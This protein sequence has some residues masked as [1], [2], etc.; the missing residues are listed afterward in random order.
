MF[1]LNSLL[2]KSYSMKQR[3]RPITKPLRPPIFKRRLSI[4]RKLALESLICQTLET[5][6][7]YFL[8]IQTFLIIQWRER[9]KTID[10]CENISREINQSTTVFL[11]LY[12]V[13]VFQ[14]SLQSTAVPYIIKSSAVLLVLQQYSGVFFILQFFFK[15]HL[16][17]NTPQ[18]TQNTT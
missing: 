4:H 14:T 11:L 16:T 3:L 5:F 18:I 6:N 12:V 7:L 13:Y 15:V 10:I 8:I 17:Q 9:A 1:A 2:T